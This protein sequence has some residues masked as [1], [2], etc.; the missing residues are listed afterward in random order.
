MCVVYRMRGTDTALS[1]A[2]F[3]IISDCG[4]SLVRDRRA[5]NR[6]ATSEIILVTMRSRGPLIDDSD[7][8]C[9]CDLYGFDKNM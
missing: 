6:H 3:G 4:V 9:L 5:C 7:I 8:A 1:F 2:R